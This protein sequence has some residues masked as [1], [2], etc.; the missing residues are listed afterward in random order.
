MLYNVV[1]V[2]TTCHLFDLSLCVVIGYTCNYCQKF[3]LTSLAP[4]KIDFESSF[5]LTMLQSGTCDVSLEQMN[6]LL[7]LQT[8][9]FILSLTLLSSATVL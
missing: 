9:P 4:D 7:S 1:H 8:S 5:T 6:H 3:N 2:C